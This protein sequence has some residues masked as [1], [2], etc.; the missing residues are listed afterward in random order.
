MSR[1]QHFLNDESYTDWLKS[2]GC[3]IYLPLSQGDLQDKI[4]GN[5]LTLSGNGSLTWDNSQ[6]MYLC[7]T[8]SSD[9]Y[10]ASLPFPY[11]YSDFTEDQFT[12]YWTYKRVTTSG[13]F[14]S[15][16]YSTSG[17]TPVVLM[18]DGGTLNLANYGS[19]RM[20]WMM[21]EG[22]P[23]KIYNDWSLIASLSVYSPNLPSSWANTA[24]TI[25]FGVSYD[26][27]TRGKKAYMKD[28]IYFNHGLTDA[29]ISTLST[30]I[31]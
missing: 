2:I 5:Y 21:T 3:L 18:G 15:T 16:S 14:C 1:R 31:S 24:N 25:Y 9:G 20:M 19:A 13:N 27:N 6:Q 28:I 17:A 8:P 23:R 22:S 10:V 12:K 4:T 26:N 29:E 11:N 7:T 30:Y